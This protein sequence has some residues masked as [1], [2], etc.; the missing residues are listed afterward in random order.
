MTSTRHVFVLAFAL[1]PFSACT[2]ATATP[3][4]GLEITP[5][6]A[7]V[8]L[9]QARASGI[10]ATFT[11]RTSAAVT[12]VTTSCLGGSITM[13][14]A[15]LGGW[16]PLPPPNF[17]CMTSGIMAPPTINVAS[18]ASV[19]LMASGGELTDLTT[20]RYRMRVRSTG[21]DAVSGI[22]TVE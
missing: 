16:V 2:S 17:I 21:G 11:N 22:V 3:S 7:T 8:R 1:L 20:G 5:A 12:L 6:S 13:E 4:T 14:R 9:D 15:V 10:P 19:S 18:G